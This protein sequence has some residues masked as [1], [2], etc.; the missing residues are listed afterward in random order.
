MVRVPETT[1]ITSRLGTV[2]TSTQEPKNSTGE[3]SVPLFL[4]YVHFHHS[5]PVPFAIFMGI[6][7]LK[8]VFL[9]IPSTFQKGYLK[10][11]TGNTMLL[12]VCAPK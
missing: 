9:I 4:L 11:F 8:S 5:L 10:R 1:T 12:V 2:T 6:F 7:A 3:F